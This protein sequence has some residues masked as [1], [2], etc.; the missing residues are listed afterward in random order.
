V[1]CLAVLTCFLAAVLLVF[2][3]ASESP[4]ILAGDLC[5]SRVTR[6]SGAFAASAAYATAA[7][8]WRLAVA[9]EQ[10]CSD[11]MCCPRRMSEGCEDPWTT[12]F[13]RSRVPKNGRS[14]R[15]SDL[16]IEDFPLRSFAGRHNE[17]MTQCGNVLVEVRYCWQTGRLTENH[18]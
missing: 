3:R 11:K 6:R 9:R 7:A 1:F 10:P 5:L 16:W 4:T 15:R 12:I 18:N 8:A 2:Q 13:E 17:C 14:S